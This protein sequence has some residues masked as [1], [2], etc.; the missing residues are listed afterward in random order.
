VPTAIAAIALAAE[1]SADSSGSGDGLAARPTIEAAGWG[2]DA[3]D[4][5]TKPAMRRL[6]HVRGG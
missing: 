4:T 3:R 2:K 1:G 6:R 5:S